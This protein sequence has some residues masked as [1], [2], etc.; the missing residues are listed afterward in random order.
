VETRTDPRKVT[1]ILMEILV[2][3][4]WIWWKEAVRMVITSSN[5]AALVNKD[6]QVTMEDGLYVWEALSRAEEVELPAAVG[7]SGL[8][9]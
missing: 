9:S 2:R 1:Q 7:G 4:E 3:K 6:G 5:R 8:L